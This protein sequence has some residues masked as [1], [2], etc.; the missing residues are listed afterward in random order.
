VLIANATRIADGTWGS[1]D[2]RAI[3]AEA[4]TA[5]FVHEA[6]FHRELS[7]RLGVSWTEPRNGIAEIDGVPRTAIDAFSRR[8]V[9]IDAQIKAW[10]RDTAKARQSAAVQTLA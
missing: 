10:G 1:L 4:R 3:F 8:R 2:G 9:E 7:E 5:G 6:V